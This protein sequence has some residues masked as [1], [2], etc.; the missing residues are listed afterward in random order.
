MRRISN[1]TASSPQAS[2]PEGKEE[3]SQATQPFD[4]A[5]GHEPVA[6]QMA[7]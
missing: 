3:R 7:P 6:W 5:Q 4:F 1:T 2:R